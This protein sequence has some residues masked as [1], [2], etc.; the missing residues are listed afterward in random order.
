MDAAPLYICMAEFRLWL[1]AH[2]PYVYHVTY[3]RNLESIAESGLN[4]NGMGG[5]NFGKEF[6]IRHSQTGTFFVSNI[7]G[8]KYWIR[9]LEEQANDRSDNIEED[10]LIPIVLKFRLNE[11]KHLPDEHGETQWDRKTD[12]YIPAEGLWVW[13]GLRWQP[14]QEWINID[15]NRFITY[16]D[17]NY[18]SVKNPYTTA[19]GVGYPLPSM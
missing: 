13:D 15:L 14:V 10:G 12:R 1:E 18:A 19:R 17:E 5:A 11:R 4:F 3:Y 6:L 8:V 9:T 16:D 2:S 7:Q